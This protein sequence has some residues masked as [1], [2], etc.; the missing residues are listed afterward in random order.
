MNII[1]AS[2]IFCLVF[3]SQSFYL[4]KQRKVTA[5]SSLGTVMT[6]SNKNNIDPTLMM[7]L[8]FVE[9]AWKETAVSY[10]GA[11]GL[12]QVLPKYTGKITKKYT[13]DQLK[14]PIRSIVVGTKTFKWW[15]KQYNGNIARALC[16]YNAGFR[17]KGKKP[18]SNGMRYARKV[19]KVQKKIK[20]LSKKIEVDL[21]LKS[22]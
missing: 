10:A 22:R 1:I 17:C 16:G 9:S 21:L 4:S 3:S 2:K 6:E 11:C 12:T 19:F 20:A 13:C 14:N 15:I 18:N 7:S 5:C 8:I